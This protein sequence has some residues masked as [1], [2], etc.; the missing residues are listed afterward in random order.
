MANERHVPVHGGNVVGAYVLGRRLGAGG[1]GAVFEAQ[2][3]DG[4]RVAI[5]VPYNETMFDEYASRRF[6]DEGIAGSIVDHPNLARIIERGRTDNDIPYLVMDRVRGP[7]LC[8]RVNRGALSLRRTVLLIRQLLAALDALHA[9]GIIHGDVKSDNVLVE[10]ARDGSD[11]V[12]L[13]DFG[14]AR[15]ELEARSTPASHDELVSGTPDY[16][17]PEVIAGEGWSTASDIYAVGC[18]LYELVTGLTPFEGGTSVEIMQRH[19]D[20][21]VIPPSL[22]RPDRNVP[23]ILERIV[24][25]A[26]E[27]DPAKRFASANVFSSALAVALPILED[28]DATRPTAGSKTSPT[29]DF[30]RGTPACRRAKR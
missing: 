7:R 13:I 11:I 1:M 29:L 18:I 2:R 27:K 16:M 24:L 5:K 23:P 28:A 19:L 3:S 26:L 21:V 25:R 22:R 6:V 8:R 14:L 9:A 10:S 20:E 12:K 15:V 17:A 4:R 30:A